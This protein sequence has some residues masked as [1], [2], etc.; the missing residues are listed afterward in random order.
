MTRERTPEKIQRRRFPLGFSGVF[1]K[2][3]IIINIIIE[4]LEDMC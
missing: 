4:L 1:D 2:T 3:I